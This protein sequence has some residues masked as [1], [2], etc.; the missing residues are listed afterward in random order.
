ML[1]LDDPH[2][3]EKARRLIREEQFSA[4]SSWQHA[5]NAIIDLYKDLSE[6]YLRQ[7][8]VDLAD[9][10]DQVLRTL[11]GLA[12]TPLS[13]EQSSILIALEL[14]P[15]DILRLDPDKILG[16]CSALGGADSHSAILAK[17]LGIPA[18]VGLGTEILDC[19][20]RQLAMDGSSGE[21]WID[22]SDEVR[23]GIIE[24]RTVWLKTRREER[25]SSHQ[26]ARTQDGRLMQVEANIIGVND[27]RIALECGADG[28]GVMRTEFLYLQRSS[29]PDEEEQVR[30][31]ARIAAEMGQRPFTIRTLDIGGD[32]Y[33]PYI[34]L[35][36][37]DNPFLGQRGVRVYK[38]Y[39][40]LLKTQLRSI[41]RASPD[42]TLSI[43]IP[44]VSTCDE[45]RFVKS[46][47]ESAREELLSEGRQ[48]AP[49][50]QLGIMIELPSAVAL[51]DQL[52]RESDFFS[53]GTNDLCQYTLAIDRSDPEA[54]EKHNGFHPALLRL[55]RDTVAAGHR[56][57]IPV[58][59]CGE[60]AGM[61]EAAP[62]LVGLEL[63]VLS[64][65]PIS[66]P[67]VKKRISSLN[68]EDV[69]RIALE[70]LDLDSAKAVYGALTKDQNT[71]LS[72]GETDSE[73]FQ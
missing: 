4:E 65:N 71:Q 28:I 22:P 72:R 8:A 69:R 38:D 68:Y 19:S 44:M 29:A 63:D 49:K 41:L 3:V 2:L 67:A 17:A 48:L 27:A 42:H 46:V 31:Y 14:S 33:L 25:R 11:L 39:P 10:R 26:A 61:P 37:G 13:L 54:S 16:L 12:E 73:Q 66:I 23:Q 9:I 7:R 1:Y 64:M 30:A 52:A 50:V 40:D 5:V 45:I 60:L 36:T 6:P 18:V 32:K 20:G 59:L 43:M 51:A 62:L 35:Q 53:I 24:N 70:L 15:A 56:S 58:A 34:P 55:V 57:G 21:V 47:L